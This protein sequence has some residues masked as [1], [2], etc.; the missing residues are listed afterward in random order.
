MT[1]SP[2]PE[3]TI[4]FGISKKQH[5]LIAALQIAYTLYEDEL[6]DANRDRANDRKERTK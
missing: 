3:P 1:P 4:R 2:T 5:D 6:A